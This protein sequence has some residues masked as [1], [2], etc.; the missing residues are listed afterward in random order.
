MLFKKQK[1][2]DSKA[3]DSLRIINEQTPFAI[4]E[5]F[6]SLST[7]V[8]Y[9]PIVDKCKKIAITSGVPGEGKSYISTNLAITLAQNFDNKKIL[10]IDMDMRSPSIAKLFKNFPESYDSKIGL[11]E[12]LIGLS[13]EPNIV[14]TNIRGL[15]VLFAGGE[16]SN[17]AGLIN[18]DKMTDLLKSCEAKFDYIIIDT[19]PINIVSDATL[20]VGRINGYILS[21]R[22]D[23]SNVNAL[24]TA[25]KTL[26]SVG[27]QL[28]GVVL[29][30]VNPKGGMGYG[31]Y[32]K[33]GKYG[34]YGSYGQYGYGQCGDGKDE[35]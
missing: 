7:N 31:R 13:E 4:K 6:S 3:V 29:M 16:S 25:E 12:Y 28:F 21:T 2:H 19:P 9:L 24:S 35:Q 27:A 33:Y 17:P 20:L 5:A 1:V 34:K 11:S 22:A 23:Y 18:S 15:S 26:N 14:E 32:G 8:I 10:L 30:G